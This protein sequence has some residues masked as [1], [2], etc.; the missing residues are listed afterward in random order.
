M[1]LKTRWR[2][3]KGLITEEVS[4][5]GDE[6]NLDEA[7]G[8]GGYTPFGLDSNAQTSNGTLAES[9][10]G[11]HTLSGSATAVTMSLPS[12]SDVPMAEYGFRSLSAHGH[13][14]SGS[15][16][17]FAAGDDR[18][19]ADSGNVLKLEALVGASVFLKSD[20]A[21]WLTLASSGTLTFV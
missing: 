9:D 6:F 7:A 1:A 5:G 4:S 21:K 13:N 18:G 11:M 15:T 16:I 8:G 2:K 12:P 3:G 10:A 17:T 20:G 19:G 14:L